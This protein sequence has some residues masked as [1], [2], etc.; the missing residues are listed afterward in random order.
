[1]PDGAA[2]GA[3]LE[4][5]APGV[6]AAPDAPLRELT[7]VRMDVAGFVGVAPRGPAREPLV[8]ERHPRDASMVDSS[9]PRSR[10]VAV[11]V[12]SW[13]EYAR[14]FGAFEG[15][16]R[17]AYAVA[18]FFEQG[19]RRAV[20]VRIVPDA[21]GAGGAATLRLDGAGDGTGADVELVARNEG[22]WGDGLVAALSFTARP[23]LVAAAQPSNAELALDR[24]LAL[25]TLLRVVLADGSRA[26]RLV[27]AV[28][29]IAR[30][31]RPGFRHIAMFDVPLG[32]P[33]DTVEV[34]EGTLEI[35]DSDGRHERLERLGLAAGHPRWAAD[36][37]CAESA[38]VWPAAA[39]AAGE[40][41][42]A[43]P[44]LPVAH[45]RLVAA[46]ADGYDAIVPDDFFD[47][48]W[49]PGDE[50]DARVTAG[51]HALLAEEDVA[52]VVVP[53]LYEPATW[54]REPQ[55]VDP[56][57][58]AGPVFERCLATGAQVAAAPAP[59][60]LEGLV[61]DPADALDLARIVELQRRLVDLAESVRA[62]V[63]LLDV[64]PGLS[65]RAVLAW[66]A[67]W[68]SMWAAAY[69][70]WLRTAQLGPAGGST[71]RVNPAAVAAG[72]IA[73]T[74]RR[75][76]VQRGPANEL[77]ARMVDI[78]DHVGPA[79]HDELHQSGVNVYLLE[80]DGV[81]LTGARTLSRDVAWR[82]LTVRRLVSLIERSL[83]RRLQWTVFEP[84][85]AELHGALRY[86]LE[87]YLRGLHAA[88]ALRGA[89]EEEAFFVRID[90]R[91]AQLDAGR[92]VVEVGI[93]PA[94]PLEFIVLSVVRDGDGTLVVESARG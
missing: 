74:E 20:V 57:H 29:R 73:R 24:P 91:Q 75:G 61:L 14:R 84:S 2:A 68:D 36:V 78:E 67:H 47:A 69:H 50:P 92:L 56:G 25:G 27:S 89:T 55:I 31:D 80:R 3:R 9:R 48:A 30:P 72:L 37:L 65:Q 71:A 15:P 33:V 42:P 76:G 12:D 66:R 16:G 43:R 85:G 10:S 53:D 1:M 41:R 88:G 94:A 45:S 87:G 93:A 22:S 8:D 59:P 38:L 23:L 18:A 21:P 49:I 28:R 86:A 63:V 35:D 34:V 52:V 46:G 7:G 17:L 26:L 6:Y 70:P 58:R 54:E 81:R 4:V 32:S 51:V 62:F 19:G 82:Q 79:R 64:P 77:A 60:P 44:D 83:P 13:D 5:G 40:L 90:A 39:W 11:T